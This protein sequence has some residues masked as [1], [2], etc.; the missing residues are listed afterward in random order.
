[1]KTGITQC[2]VMVGRRHGLSSSAVQFS[3][4]PAFKMSANKEVGAL[5]LNSKDFDLHC[6]LLVT[7]NLGIQFGQPC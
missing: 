4:K 1:M 2:T 3:V 7:Y 5:R 6:Y